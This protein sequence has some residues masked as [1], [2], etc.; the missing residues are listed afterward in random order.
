MIDM[1]LWP[2]SIY[3]RW[4][5]TPPKEEDEYSEDT[6]E[7]RDPLGEDG[8]GEEGEDSDQKP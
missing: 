6:E 1:R 5:T 4:K 7:V 2:W 3:D 8:D